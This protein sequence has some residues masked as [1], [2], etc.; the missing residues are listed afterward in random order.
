MADYTLKTRAVALK[1]H[2]S[3]LDA[4]LSNI[5]QGATIRA[6]EKAAEDAENLWPTNGNPAKAVLS[7]PEKRAAGAAPHAE[8]SG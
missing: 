4:E 2:L 5:A 7:I 1:K 3:G 8:K 6:I